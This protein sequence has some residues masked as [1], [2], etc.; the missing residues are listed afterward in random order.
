MANAKM[1]FEVFLFW[2]GGSEGPMKYVLKHGEIFLFYNIETVK[3]NFNKKIMSKFSRAD[4]PIPI[5]I[6]KRPKVRL[7]VFQ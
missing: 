3:V 7:G 1:N 5:L 6:Q 4:G 2:A